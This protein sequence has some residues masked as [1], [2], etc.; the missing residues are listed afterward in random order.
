MGKIPILH[1][2]TKEKPGFFGTRFRVLRHFHHSKVTWTPSGRFS[3]S[4]RSVWLASSHDERLSTPT[5][6]FFGSL[7]NKM[8]ITLSVSMGDLAV[9]LKLLGV[10]Y[11]IDH[12]F[13]LIGVRTCFLKQ[14]PLCPRPHEVMRRVLYFIIG[15]AVDVV[16]EETHG[17]HVGK[18][19]GGIRQQLLFKRREERLCAFQ[20]ALRERLEDRH[21]EVD[22]I[23][24]GV[25][26]NTRVGRRTQ[27]VAKIGE[28]ETGHHGIQVNDAEHIAILIEKHV[29]DFGVAMANAFWQLAL[30]VEHL[31][32]AHPLRC[33]A[34][35]GDQLLNLHLAHLPDRVGSHS[36]LQLLQAELD[37]VEIGN[38]LPYRCFQV[39]QQRLEI[40]EG[41]ASVIGILRRNG[42]VGIA[43][44]NEVH[45]SPILAIL[46]D[47]GLARVGLQ[48]MQHAP[49]NILNALTLIFLPNMIRHR[50][51]IVLQHFHV[52]E[53]SIVDAL[54]HIFRLATHY[55]FIGVVDESVAQRLDG[56]DGFWVNE[57]AR[58]GEKCVHDD[59]FLAKIGIFII[60]IHIFAQISNLSTWTT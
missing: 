17:L 60:L 9:K 36:V 14:P 54:Q 21:V 13:H 59:K 4:K 25:I 31:A 23:Q 29:V 7:G 2:T 45:H 49:I 24:V 3:N 11:A 53:H 41:T 27:E 47:V 56:F 15:V 12:L 1:E 8:R 52:G 58:D 20:I 19:R 6:T 10:V 51:N 37:I 50:F 43:V 38:D 28:D 18:Q 35:L 16:G 33:L 22:V 46:N 42:L 32:E 26:L 48:E 34:Y 55:D 44:G 57:M 40:T 30:A 39:R 5:S